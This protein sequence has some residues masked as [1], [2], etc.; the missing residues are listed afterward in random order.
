MPCLS[1][2]YRVKGLSLLV[3]KLEPRLTLFILFHRLFS[4]LSPKSGAQDHVLLKPE[5]EVPTTESC[6]SQKPLSCVC[7][8]CSWACSCLF[9]IR[10][11]MKPRYVTCY[12]HT[13]AFF[14]EP[15]H[16][17]LADFRVLMVFFRHFACCEQVIHTHWS[18]NPSQQFPK[19]GT[20]VFSPWET[21]QPHCWT[22]CVSGSC[23]QKADSCSGSSA[24]RMQ[25]KVSFKP[26]TENQHCCPTVAVS[27]TYGLL[28]RGCKSWALSLIALMSWTVIRTL[29]S[30]A[31][32]EDRGYHSH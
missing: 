25:G 19:Q 7:L 16:P 13:W 32:W 28:T 27:R 26:R 9:S 21:V 2:T 24:V 14:R 11:R 20:D 5:L 8:G 6:L 22:P 12:L 30:S 23:H 29:L 15:F 10:Q 17:Q 3:P 31:L 18:K 1:W 4:A